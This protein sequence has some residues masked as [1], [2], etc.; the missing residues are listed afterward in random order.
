MDKDTIQQIAAEVVARLPITGYDWLPL[1]VQT[2]L[3]LV[4]AVGAALSGPYLMTRAKQLATK[5]DF[6]ELQT[7]LKANTELVEMIKSEVSQRDWAQREWTN[8]RRSVP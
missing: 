1:V 7:Q 5:H 2:I 6:D 4:V 8:I 3:M